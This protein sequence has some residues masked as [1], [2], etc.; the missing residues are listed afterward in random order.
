MWGKKKGKIWRNFISL[1][2]PVEVLFFPFF[3]HSYRMCVPEFRCIGILDSIVSSTCCYLN[4]RL[5]KTL[6]VE[7]KKLLIQCEALL[8][9]QP[10]IV[11][12]LLSPLMNIIFREINFVICKWW[13]HE[14]FWNN[15]LRR[16]F[17]FC[18]LWKITE[19][20]SRSHSS[21]TK[22]SWK[23]RFY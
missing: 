16:E 22:I 23:Y 3:K 2:Q 21:L 8:L 20:Y 13:L 15:T 6:A 10:T 12:F 4:L 7:K 11:R 5:T 1:I 14:I 9:T 19:I 18:T 17:S